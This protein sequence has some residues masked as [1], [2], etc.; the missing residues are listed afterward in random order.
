LPAAPRTD[1]YVRNYLIRLLPWVERRDNVSR[2]HPLAPHM[3]VPAQCP[4]MRARSEFPSVEPLPS[5]DS[6]RRG[7]TRVCSPASLV[8]RVRLTSRQRARPP[9]RHRRSRTA[10]M[11]S[12][13]RLPGSPGSRVWNFH[14]CSGSLTPPQPPAPCLVGAGD[15]AFSLSGQNRPAKVMF[16]ELHGWPAFPSLPMLSPTALLRWTLGERPV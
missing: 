8:L 5:A 2:T 1:P 16:S 12:Q 13:R 10:P 15:I 7:R 4:A 9:C 3:V 14:A 6:A 11:G